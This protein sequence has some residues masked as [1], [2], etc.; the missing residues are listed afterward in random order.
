MG[1]GLGK[2]QKKILEVMD[3][4]PQR[5]FGARELA[6]LIFGEDA[7]RE[8]WRRKYL[9]TEY[10]AAIAR[11][12]RGLEKRGLIVKIRRGSYMSLK[13]KERVK[14]EIA[15]R[16]KLLDGKIRELEREYE[17]LQEI[18]LQLEKVER[19]EEYIGKVIGKP[20]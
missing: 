9:K 2:L 4:N 18:Y 17:R 6:E 10:Q 20:T 3:K 1:R 13:D 19:M 7:F 11:A 5:V 14:I 15:W 16:M 8:G 12:L